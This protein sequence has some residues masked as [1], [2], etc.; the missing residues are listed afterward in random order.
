MNTPTD[1]EMLDWIEKQGQ[2]YKWNVQTDKDFPFVRDCF[3]V[4]RNSM[5]GSATAREAIALAMER[6]KSK[7]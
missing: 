6:S 5:S 2:Y 4:Q 3:W 7:I 1:T